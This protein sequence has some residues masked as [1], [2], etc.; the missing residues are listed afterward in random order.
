M[1]PML[2]T[3]CFW[4]ATASAA[5][6]TAPGARASAQD[7]VGTDPIACWWATDKTSVEVGERFTLTLTCGVIDASRVKVVADLNQLEPAA[8][9][10][11]PFEV[12]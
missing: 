10:L 5:G 4:P 7:E 8:V 12:V 6:L 11:A 3:V 2:A 1:W 9:A